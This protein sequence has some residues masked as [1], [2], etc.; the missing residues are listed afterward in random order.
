MVLNHALIFVLDF[1]LHHF[2][3]LLEFFIVV[4][5]NFTVG[6]LGISTVL[7]LKLL[8]LVFEFLYSLPHLG[9]GAI[10]FLID[11]G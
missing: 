2:D 4:F 1:L 9:D 8:N 3:L 6:A 7:G 10:I 11:P 5:E